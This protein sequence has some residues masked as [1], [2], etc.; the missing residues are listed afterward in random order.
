MKNIIITNI[1]G[2]LILTLIGGCASS[3]FNKAKSINTIESYKI[4]LIDYEE[5]PYTF[6]VD[7]DILLGSK[8]LIA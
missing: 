4:F 2:M 8:V 1:V 5:S 3:A 7:P 6:E